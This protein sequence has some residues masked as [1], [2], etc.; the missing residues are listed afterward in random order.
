M[1]YWPP[2]RI[3]AT[4]LE[5]DGFSA[6]HRTRMY[7]V[8][9]MA[10]FLEVRAREEYSRWVNELMSEEAAIVTGVRSPGVGAYNHQ[11]I[12]CAGIS[13]FSQLPEAKMHRGNQ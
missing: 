3:C 7:Y 2:E 12:T 8:E 4:D 9:I 5:M 1:V 13:C 6:T 11:S 10:I